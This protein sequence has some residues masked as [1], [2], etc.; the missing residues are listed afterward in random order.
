W[1]AFEVIVNHE[2]DVA[3]I[4]EVRIDDAAI[5]ELEP[6]GRRQLLAREGLPELPTADLQRSLAGVVVGIEVPQSHLPGSKVGFESILQP[7]GERLSMEPNAGVRDKECVSVEAV[8]IIT[9]VDAE[10]LKAPLHTP[11]NLETVDAAI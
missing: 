2:T 8:D 4:V 10:E 9:S 1:R 5:D 3:A 11:A 6:F 7:F